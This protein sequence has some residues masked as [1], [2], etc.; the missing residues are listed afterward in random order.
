[1]FMKDKKKPYQ[2]REMSIVVAAVVDLG[3]NQP[4][5]SEK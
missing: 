1:M 3:I 4:L 5:K 2:M